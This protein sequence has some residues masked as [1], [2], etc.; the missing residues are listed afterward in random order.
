MHLENIIILLVTTKYT[1][2]VIISILLEL[3]N[4]TQFD[5]HCTNWGK[6]TVEFVTRSD[7]ILITTEVRAI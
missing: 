3:N 4:V 2:I 5:T 1:E 7:Y 6:V